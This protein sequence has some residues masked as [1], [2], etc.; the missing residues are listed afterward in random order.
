M[1]ILMGVLLLLPQD[2]TKDDVVRL[3]QAGATEEAI[4]GKIGNAKFALGADD[5]VALKK[6]GVPD[7]VVARMVSG[8]SELK[9]ENLSHR[10]VGVTI[11]GN[12]ITV[13]LGDQYAPGSKADLAASGEYTLQ[14]PGRRSSTTLKTPAT[15]TFR[16]CN[17]DRFEVVTLY[18][19]SPAGLDT[20]F[21]ELNLRPQAEA[22]AFPGGV[23]PS[24][25]APIRLRRSGFLE[26][27]MDAM[28]SACSRF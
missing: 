19:E 21:V 7:R 9:L 28:G 11:Q 25:P 22:E 26:L 18:I 24:L 12:V 23:P 4:L 13:G 20:C 14:V 10:G 2:L 27:L 15:L 8:P 3:V 16:G 17:L 6:A 5:V 1:S